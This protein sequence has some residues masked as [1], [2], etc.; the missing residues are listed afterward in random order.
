MCCWKRGI[1]FCLWDQKNI[2]ILI[3]YIKYFKTNLFIVFRWTF[4]WV[5]CAVDTG[6]SYEVDILFP[7]TFIL[8]F[9]LTL[10][11]L[12]RLLVWF[13]FVNFSIRSIVLMVIFVI[14]TFI[15]IK[16]KIFTMVFKQF[17][18][19]KLLMFVLLLM[20]LQWLFSILALLLFLFLELEVRLEILMKLRIII[21]N[22]IVK[23]RVLSS[24]S[25]NQFTD[26]F[27]F[28]LGMYLCEWINSLEM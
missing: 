19:L 23:F 8:D 21:I 22:I 20:E 4:L 18:I 15:G 7:F 12:S 2:N 11:I 28:L 27:S 13:F 17:Q 24:G 6:C 5:F 16:M 1:N 9:M 25:Y 10:K 3:D 14:A 26:F